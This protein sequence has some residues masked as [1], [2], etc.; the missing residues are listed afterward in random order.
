LADSK[1]A[2]AW[3]IDLIAATAIFLTSI[4]FFYL[5]AMNYPTETENELQSLTYEAELVADSLLS[6]GLPIDWTPNNVI[7][8]GLLSDNK[9][10]QTKLEYFYSLSAN[11]QKTKS[12]FRVKNDYFV[13]FQEPMTING[14]PVTGI[15]NPA[16]AN[17]NLI[18]ISRI[19]V[20]ND[21]IATLNIYVWN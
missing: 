14:S 8:I 5:Y 13:Y 12:L 15:G 7:K 2:Q 3:G 18:K 6:E 20:Y 16:A 21:N 19:V 4:I 1:R 11:Y 17:Q 9:I 10:N